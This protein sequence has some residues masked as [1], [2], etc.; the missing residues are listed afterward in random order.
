MLLRWFGRWLRATFDYNP[1]FPLSALLLLAGVRLLATDGTVSAGGTIDAG[2]PGLTALGISIF[3]AYEL[4]TLG[5]ALLVLWPRRIAYETTSILR[6]FAVV[7]FAAPFLLTGLALDYVDVPGSAPRDGHPEAAA[8]MGL[9]LTALMALKGEL[10]TSRVGLDLKPW[11]RGWDYALFGLSAVGV[12]LFAHRLSAWTGQAFSGNA[13]RALQMALWWGHAALLAPLAL[14][15]PD[16]G[17]AGPLQSRRPAAWWR[18]LSLFGYSALLANGLHV[19]GTPGTPLLAWFP[20]ALVAVAVVGAIGR[21]AGFPRLA[22]VEH[23][24]ALLGAALLLFDERQL[25]GGILTRPVALLL[26][27]PLAALSLPLLAPGRA[28]RGLRSLGGL[29]ILA[30]LSL[31]PGPDQVGT[32]LLALG[33]LGVGLGLV[34]RH[35]LLI[36]GGGALGTL[37]AL[38]LARHSGWCGPHLLLG[39]AGALSGLLAARHPRAPLALRLCAG[40]YGVGWGLSAI[41]SGIDPVLGLELVL[42]AGAMAALGLRAGLPSLAWAAGAS[43]VGITGW[44]GA[45]KLDPGVA[46]VGLAFAAVPAGTWIALRR[47]AR[48]REE[49]RLAA[50]RAAGAGPDDE[51]DDADLDDA[52]LDH[53]DLDHA[54][55][56]AH[57]DEP[58]DPHAHELA[59]A[60]SELDAAGPDPIEGAAPTQPGASQPGA[61]A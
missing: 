29:V 27:T 45:G 28:G 32:Y 40:L 48:S 55:P 9:A 22:P 39:A 50:Q 53:A 58:A 4:V 13:A 7:R 5:A 38:V 6:V 30:P 34:R 16:L 3:Q 18:I 31:L 47:E 2:S 20:L 42:G 23:L 49:E 24:P 25:L 51:P 57:A 37:A 61:S 44:R 11:E 46:L 52:D 8:L 17:R 14:G 43:L 21:A 41:R 56:N 12:P 33:G 54:D 1:T 26:W 19:A 15:L 60:G 36:A 35:D 10:I 59:L